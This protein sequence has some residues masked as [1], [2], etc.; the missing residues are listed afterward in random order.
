MWT[1]QA[2][3][4]VGGGGWW[5]GAHSCLVLAIRPQREMAIQD[6]KIL[7]SFVL[8]SWSPFGRNRVVLFPHCKAHL[9]WRR[10]HGVEVRIPS[11]RCDAVSAREGR[12]ST[13]YL[14]LAAI[15]LTKLNRYC[16]D[17]L[18]GSIFR[19]PFCHLPSSPPSFSFWTHTV[20]ISGR[21]FFSFQKTC[22][23]VTLLE[24]AWLSVTFSQSHAL[25]FFT[26]AQTGL[27]ST[28]TKTGADPGDL[29]ADQTEV[30]GTSE[31]THSPRGTRVRCK[32]CMQIST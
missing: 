2:E 14:S 5:R 11:L 7:F 21:L 31:C 6:T 27:H 22:P 19:D 9:H 30:G 15:S 28:E 12:M 8:V 16:V 32:I 23:I 1:P 10:V 17:L 3:K 18:S 29:H 25:S 20:D 13:Q 24:S 4:R 26:Q